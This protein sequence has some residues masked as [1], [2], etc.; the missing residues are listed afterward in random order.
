MVKSGCTCLCG[1]D[2]LGIPVLVSRDIVCDTYTKQSDSYLDISL[3]VSHYLATRQEKFTY[4]SHYNQ[5]NDWNIK[6]CNSIQ[7]IT[8][9]RK[10][11]MNLKFEAIAV[12]LTHRTHDAKH[13]EKEENSKCHV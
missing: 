1:A 9:I 11:N 5:D 10:V 3:R 12:S 6:R 4:S 2:A 8:T 7:N 13:T